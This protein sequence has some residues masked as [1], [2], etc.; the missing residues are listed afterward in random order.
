MT[1]EL[2]N[3]KNLEML[4]LVCL[5]AYGYFPVFFSDLTL[6]P[7]DFSFVVFNLRLSRSIAKEDLGF[8]MT[9]HLNIKS[10]RIQ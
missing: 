9:K 3:N 8:S 1:R 4:K 10:L 5:P 7:R 6:F 2:G